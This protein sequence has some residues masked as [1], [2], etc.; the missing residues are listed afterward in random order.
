MRL[1]CRRSCLV[2]KGGLA[3]AAAKALGTQ[4]HHRRRRPQR[5]HG[6]GAEPSEVA[7]AGAKPELAEL[8][9]PS[10][11]LRVSGAGASGARDLRPDAAAPRSTCDRAAFVYGGPAFGRSTGPRC[12]ARGR[13]AG[14]GAAAGVVSLASDPAAARES[15]ARHRFAASRD[16]PVRNPRAP[17]L[18]GKSGR[19]HRVSS[20]AYPLGRMSGRT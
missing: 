11:R 1:S 13:G 8:S 12:A 17:V 9:C 20:R 15:P 19:A 7:A 3:P 18:G 10:R 2:L 4:R 5:S 14:G 16:C 6:A